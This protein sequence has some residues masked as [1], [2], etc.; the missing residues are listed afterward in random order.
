[1]KKITLFVNFFFVKFFCCLLISELSI[2]KKKIEYLK[3]FFKE[4]SITKF[5]FYIFDGKTKPFKSVQFVNFL[6]ENKKYWNNNKKSNNPK[7]KKKY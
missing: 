4:I 1:M 2:I 3:F 5:V 7:N 6:N